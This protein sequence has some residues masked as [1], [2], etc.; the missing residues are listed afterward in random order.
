MLAQD[1]GRR[2]RS[3]GPGADPSDQCSGSAKRSLLRCGRGQVRACG[4]RSAWHTLCVVR[5]KVISRPKRILSWKQSRGSRDNPVCRLA[6]GA[7]YAGH[8]SMFQ[9][10]VEHAR[11]SATPH[12]QESAPLAGSALLRAAEQLTVAD[13]RSFEHGLGD[14]VVRPAP[15]DDILA[16]C[17][18]LPSAPSHKYSC[19]LTRSARLGSIQP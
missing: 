9:P 6:D 18:P 17:D 4:S 2:K 1:R 8:P 16:A 19:E 3:T 5:N 12:P 10:Y 11:A 14:A 15:V 7:L 13:L